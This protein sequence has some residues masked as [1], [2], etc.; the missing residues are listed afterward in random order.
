[1]MEEKLARLQEKFSA[2][3]GLAEQVFALE[4]SAE[5]Q[6]FLEEQGLEFTLEEIDLLKESIVKSLAQGGELSDEDL[7]EVAGGL[8]LINIPSIQPV[9][10]PILLPGTPEPGFGRRW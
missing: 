4:T 8:G 5:V 1:M 6:S 2:D 10:R 3:P 7:E 9:I